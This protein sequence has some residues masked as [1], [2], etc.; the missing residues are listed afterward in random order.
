MDELFDI[1]T[2][3]I[4]NNQRRSP[5]MPG[6]HP[7]PRDAYEQP[8]QMQLG[9]SKWVVCPAPGMILPLRV[10]QILSHFVVNALELGIVLPGNKQRGQ[11]H[12]LKRAPQRRLHPRS[13]PAQAVG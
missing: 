7:I 12:L 6:R 11:R 3:L 8:S 9:R 1:Y 4:H 10:R 5:I 13:H 2:E